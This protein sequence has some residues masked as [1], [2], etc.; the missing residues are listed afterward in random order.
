MNEAATVTQI[1]GEQT[2]IETAHTAPGL[3][4][5]SP[6][7]EIVTQGCQV[8]D[9][10]ESVSSLDEIRDLNRHTLTVEQA[11]A[12][13][14]ILEKQITHQITHM[15]NC[16]GGNVFRTECVVIGCNGKAIARGYGAGFFDSDESCPSDAMKTAEKESFCGAVWSAFAHLIAKARELATHKLDRVQP[17]D[18][19][20]M[21]Q[22]APR[23]MKDALRREYQHAKIEWPVL[24]AALGGVEWSSILVE[25]VAMAYRI[26]DEW[27]A[28]HEKL[29]GRMTPLTEGKIV[30]ETT[31]TDESEGEIETL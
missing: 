6:L 18:R 28:A 14:A 30:T 29:L 1:L 10:L 3:P 5:Q 13:C 21:P 20:P 27:P 4:R 12:I 17:A 2:P 11:A 15:E 31:P 25:Q 19:R 23:A 8:F 22:F 16:Q 9:A 24:K 26:I 7:A